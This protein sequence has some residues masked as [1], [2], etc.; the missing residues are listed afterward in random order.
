MASMGRCHNGEVG[1]G[2]NILIYK[3]RNDARKYLLS[4]LIKYIFLY[5]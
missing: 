1:F 4:I 2:K 3:R 5:S